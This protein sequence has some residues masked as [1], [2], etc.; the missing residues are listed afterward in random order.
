MRTI[1]LC[2]ISDKFLRENCRGS[3]SPNTCTYCHRHG[4]SITLRELAEIADEPLRT[5]C[6][7]GEEY[8]VR[9]PD[10]EKYHWEEHGDSLEYFLQEELGIEWEP[11]TDLIEILDQSDSDGF[12]DAAHNYHRQPLDS[13]EYEYTW[14]DFQHRICHQRR[15]FDDVAERYLSEILGPSESEEATNLPTREIGPGAQ[16]EWIYRARRADSEKKAR[17]ISQTPETEL[18]PPPD[19]TASAGR[20]NPAGISVFYGAL[21]EDASIA[22]V[23]PSVGSLVVVGRFRPSRILRLLDLTQIGTVFPLSIFQSDYARRAAHLSFLAGFHSRIAKPVQ[24]HDEPIEYIPTQAV[25]EYVTNVLDFDG[26]IYASAQLGVLQMTEPPLYAYGEPPNY[27]FPAEP[28][29]GISSC[30]VVLFG[31]AG[32]VEATKETAPQKKVRKDVPLGELDFHDYDPTWTPPDPPDAV[33]LPCTDGVRIIRITAVKYE[34]E[35][36]FIEG[37]V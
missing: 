28:C 29:E 8:P 5:Y 32:R 12:F 36:T 10:S 19:R 4:S 21:S 24:P 30:N 14:L 1:C 18:G 17:S 6:C 3:A 7:Q 11:A 16:I 9:K 20:M 27:A 37:N 25:A 31:G 23:R 13:L 35:P 22:E 15:F 33:L 34:H 2:C 26:M